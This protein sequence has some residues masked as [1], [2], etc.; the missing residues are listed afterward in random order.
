[1]G[2]VPLRMLCA[3]AY[4]PPA[5]SGSTH[6]HRP[7]AAPACG[8]QNLKLRQA[9]PEHNCDSTYD[10]SH[11]HGHEGLS[12]K[13]NLSLVLLGRFLNCV[14]WESV[15]LIFGNHVVYISQDLLNRY[16]RSKD[17]KNMNT[18]SAVGVPGAMSAGKECVRPSAKKN[19]TNPGIYGK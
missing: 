5:A 19:L 3:D 6:A 10:Q 14:R 8:P 1:M 18:P 16:Q 15:I 11:K 9:Q 7:A 4:P 13:H 17:Y 12:Q 2:N